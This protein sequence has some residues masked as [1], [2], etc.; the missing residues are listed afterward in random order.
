VSSRWT[1]STPRGSTSTTSVD[2]FCRL[3][4]GAGSERI[5]PLAERFHLALD[6]PF[7]SLSKGNKQ[8]VGVIQA[9]AHNPEL[10]ILDEPTSGLDPLLQREFQTL[11]SEASE[12]GATLLISSHIL[13]E[14]E[15]VAGRVALIR[16][17]RIADIEQVDILKQ[18]AGQHVEL[19]FAEAP[20]AQHFE[21]LEELGDLVISGN[22]LTAVLRGSPDRLLK[23][24]A[25][26]TVTHWSAR[27]RNLE[28]LFMERYR[29]T[30]EDAG[31]VS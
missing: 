24:A 12:D 1:A 22:I 4:G 19:R 14:V 18:R 21:S 8:K 10:L 11:A 17:G 27:D 26:H 31:E 5:E 9:F 28:E 13:G 6:R 7:K 23:A 16:G 25:T 2:Y 3:R 30:P 15:A 29:E 20:D